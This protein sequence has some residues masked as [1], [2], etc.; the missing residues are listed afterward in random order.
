MVKEMKHR[1]YKG[2]VEGLTEPG[3]V[4]DTEV[5]GFAVKVTP[6]GKKVYIVENSVRGGSKK[7]TV[8]IGPH[9]LPTMRARK[10]KRFWR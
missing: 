3:K 8:T 7:V 1:L 5:K 2:F 4:R 9:G 10:R 6:A